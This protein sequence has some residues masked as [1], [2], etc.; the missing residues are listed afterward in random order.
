MQWADHALRRNI[1]LIFSP[2]WVPMCWQMK[3][4]ALLR[5]FLDVHGWLVAGRVG[6]KVPLGV[7]DFV[8]RRGSED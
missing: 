5:G 6:M 8:A 3:K 7:F 4:D 1:G 2:L